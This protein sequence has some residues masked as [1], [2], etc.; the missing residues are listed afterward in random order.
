M[1][2]KD[3]NESYS[4]LEFKDTEDLNTIMNQKL[5]IM[6]ALSVFV[7]GHEFTP[8]FRAGVWDGKKEFYK[9]HP[10]GLLIYKGLVQS[11]ISKFNHFMTAEYI[12]LEPVPSVPEEVLREYID[13]LNLPFPPRDYQFEAVFKAINEGRK[14]SVLATGSGKSLIQ[15]IIMRWFAHTN[16]KGILIVP[17]VGLAEQMIND[18]REYNMGEEL[19]QEMVHL[20]YAGKAKHFDLPITISTWQSTY[21]EKN[22]F[23]QLEYILID[24]CH[25]A[26]AD[27]LQEILGNS[28]NCKYKLGF[29][30]TLPKSYVDRFTLTA[31]L[32]KSETIINAQGL[33]ERGYATPVEIV[34]MYLNYSA[35]EKQL[36]KRM[37]Y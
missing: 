33:I 19:L 35:E 26:K 12:P 9:I 24:E 13:T 2:I 28:N 31:T 30:G 15:Y 1:I 8:R 34:L 29:T 20:I 21:K 16:R 17:N 14:T 18:F 36:V 27:S 4:L 6:E 11:V 37:K 10:Q 5:E 25:L 22:L 23:N 32:G 7:D 3:L